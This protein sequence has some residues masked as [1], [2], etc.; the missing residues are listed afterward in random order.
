MGDDSDSG[1][2]GVLLGQGSQLLGDLDN[3]CGAPA[4]VFGIGD[5]LGLV[6]D[7]E[8]GVG[9]DAVELVLEELRDEWGREGEHEDLV[10]LLS[11]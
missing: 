5:G 2:A 7:E 11:G 3:V 9:D 4:V 1:A 8:V 6:T 10:S